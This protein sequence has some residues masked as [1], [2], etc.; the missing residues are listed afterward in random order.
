[1][2]MRFV[3]PPPEQRT[4]TNEAWLVSEIGAIDIGTIRRR[5]LTVLWFSF[6]V[7]LFCCLG[8]IIDP[9]F[10]FWPFALERLQ[11]FRRVE[12]SAKAS[13]EKP[14][15][16]L[17]CRLSIVVCRPEADSASEEPKDT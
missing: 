3:D 15:S 1:M 11:L 5:R 10:R 6:G 17:L 14:P 12:R 2:S 4:G 7:L 9:R 8:I 13:K 16:T